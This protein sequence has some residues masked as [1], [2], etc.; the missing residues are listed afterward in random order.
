MTWWTRGEERALKTQVE[1]LGKQ[2][3]EAARAAAGGGGG[4]GDG[5]GGGGAVRDGGRAAAA[6]AAAAGGAAL[7]EQQ[8]LAAHWRRSDRVNDD[9]NSRNNALRSLAGSSSS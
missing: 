1:A 3:E 6:E 9:L 5:G 8:R 2:L 7:Q 4:G